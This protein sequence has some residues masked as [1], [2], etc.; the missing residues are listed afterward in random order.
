MQALMLSRT[1]KCIYYAIDYSI[2]VVPHK[3][4]AEV[5]RIGNV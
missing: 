5:S 4:V 1:R 2:P 3:A